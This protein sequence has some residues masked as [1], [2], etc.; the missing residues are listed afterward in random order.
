VVVFGTLSVGGMVV[1]RPP[2]PL[3]PQDVSEMRP[4]YAAPIERVETHVLG[5]GETLSEVFSRASIAG[6]QMTNLL[7]GLRQHVNP[8]RLTDG[9]EVTIRRWIQTGAPRVV[10]VR[11]NADSTLRL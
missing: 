4:I 11:L 3:E 6:Q 9:V 5:S 1:M 10:E 2:T 7:M 8:R